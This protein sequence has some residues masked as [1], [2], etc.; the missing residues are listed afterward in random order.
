MTKAL[1]ATCLNGVVKVGTLVIDGA[2]IF[3]DG[4]GNSEGVLFIDN[5]KFYYFPS[6]TSDL[7]TTIEK[8]ISALNKIGTTLTSIGAGMTGATTSPPPT[9]AA[10]VLFLTGI[11][12]DLT[13]LKE[14]LK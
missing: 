8:L 6:T 14:T 3:S 2:E 12:T 4:V 5:G 13:T 11:A 7:K 10:D 9:L 1:N